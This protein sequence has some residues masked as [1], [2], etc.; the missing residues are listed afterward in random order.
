MNNY[1]PHKII[2]F[3]LVKKVIRLSQNKFIKCNNLDLLHLDSEYTYQGMANVLVTSWGT[4]DFV[5]AQC[6][7]N[8]LSHV[9]QSMK[10]RNW[11][12]L[13]KFQTKGK[14]LSLKFIK[15]VF[16]CEGTITCTNAQNYF[17]KEILF[18]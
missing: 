15:I 12:D 7:K 3:W 5:H 4:Q 9:F 2:T 11:K 16:F 6:N 1:S 18:Q 17:I 8:T 10:Q 13:E 14:P